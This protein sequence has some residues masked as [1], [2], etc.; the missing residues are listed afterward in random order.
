MKT[1][2]KPGEINVD[3]EQST[4]DL[5]IKQNMINCNPPKIPVT[6]VEMFVK[7]NDNDELA[8]ATSYRSLIG[9]LLSCRT[10]SF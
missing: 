4:E 10:N 2:K 3:Q 8:D 6:V 7:A 9:S 1:E 5:L